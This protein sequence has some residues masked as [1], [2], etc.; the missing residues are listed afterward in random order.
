MSCGCVDAIAV[1]VR[2]SA[3]RISDEA[4]PTHAVAVSTSAES[5]QGARMPKTRS[6]AVT[7]EDGCWIWQGNIHPR[8]GYGQ[9]WSRRHQQ[10]RPAYLVIWELHHGPVPDGLGLDH[11]CH[12][13][14]DCAGG[15]D[16]RHRRCVNPHHLAPTT[17]AENVRRGH[18]A[19][20]TWSD[21][22]EIRASSEPQYLLAERYGVH[23]SQISR[24]INGHIWREETR[25]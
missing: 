23:S 22:D 16:C 25:P 4:L 11:L 3:V 18:S 1:T 9:V 13:V 19:T 24:V 17:S 6:F 14:D 8:T 5:S 12:N 15:P 20:L 21:V 7:V 10:T 2:S